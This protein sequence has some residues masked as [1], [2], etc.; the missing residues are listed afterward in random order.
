MGTATLAARRSHQD[1]RTDD[2]PCPA[3][4]ILADEWIRTGKMLG[5]NVESDSVS[6]A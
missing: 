3:L 4:I 1:L 6:Q 5:P 2:L